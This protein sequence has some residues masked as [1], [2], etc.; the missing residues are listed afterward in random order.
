MKTQQ[1]PD[2]EALKKIT[3]RSI[4][5]PLASLRASGTQKEKKLEGYC[6]KYGQRSEVIYD[7]MGVYYEILESGCASKFLSRSD[8]DVRALY[9][10]HDRQEVLGRTT[11][12][13]LE[14]SD[15]GK[16]LYCVIH[17]PNTTA[18]HDI[19]ESVSR[20]DITGMSFTFRT[21]ENGEY[22][23]FPKGELS[24]RHVTE[25][26]NILDVTPASFPYYPSTTLVARSQQFGGERA[27]ETQVIVRAMQDPE[28][29]PS[30]SRYSSAFQRAMSFLSGK[31]KKSEPP[32]NE[33]P[34]ARSERE[35]LSD[36]L[37]LERLRY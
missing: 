4:F 1:P 10:Q 21:T 24:E 8:I 16:G 36:F 31:M 30:D 32:S 5:T 19:Y 35:E 25:I 37:E 28:F 3:E 22:W 13:T 26:D 34:A 7:W 14:L 29:D 33:A 12:R 20:G 23:H 6:A 27:E 15:D 18:G 11:A 17:L 2:L 9:T